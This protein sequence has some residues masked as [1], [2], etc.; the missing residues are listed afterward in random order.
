[1]RIKKKRSGAHSSRIRNGTV[2]ARGV[3]PT[4]RGY[5][6]QDIHLVSRRIN[7]LGCAQVEQSTWSGPRPAELTGV[8]FW[9]GQSKQTPCCGNTSSSRQHAARV[10]FRFLRPAEKPE[11]FSLTFEKQHRATGRNAAEPN[12]G[13]AELLRPDQVRFSAFRKAPQLEVCSR[14]AATR[15][16]KFPPA[17]QHT[18]TNTCHSNSRN[19]LSVLDL[20]KDHDDNQETL[21][22]QIKNIY[23]KNK[24]K[25]KVP[26]IFH[27][28]VLS[29]T[30]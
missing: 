4:V 24:Q 1:M 25:K 2:G 8:A 18:Q 10:R 22:R 30:Q 26:Q 11:P 15:R 6:G 19:M 13:S 21:K 17:R 5:Y 9:R 20:K 16:A 28:Q 27:F 7:T 29:W 14:N 12:N 3:G 23:I